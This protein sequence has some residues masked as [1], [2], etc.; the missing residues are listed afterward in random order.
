MKVDRRSFIRNSSMAA[1]AFTAGCATKGPTIINVGP[2]K[3]Y[4]WANLLQLG[5]NL[6]ND[7]VTDPAKPYDNRAAEFLRF[8]ENVWRDLTGKMRDIGMNML[9]IDL[10]EGLEYP[11]H[12]ELAVKGSW[13]PAK[14]RAELKRLRE[15]GIEPIPKLNFSATHDVWLKEYSMMLSTRI[16]HEVIGDL[17]KDVCEIFDNP[18]FVHIGMDEESEKLQTKFR[19]GVTRREDIWFND[20]KK[21]VATVER[22][23]ARAWM[24]GDPAWNYPEFYKHVPRSVMMS[25]WYYWKDAKEMEAKLDDPSFKIGDKRPDCPGQNHAAEFKAFMDL[26]KGGYEQMPCGTNWNNDGNMEAIV[27]YSIRRL[28]PAKMK[29]FL[30]TP[31]KCTWNEEKALK[32]HE[33]FFRLVDGIIKKYDA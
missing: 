25:N 18:R 7:H 33:S 29:G 27:D 6:W 14:L 9:V 5:C 30:L 13:S 17:V 11:S 31:W 26:Q 22:N 8:D 2:K 23:G 10:A 12:P 28:D 4:I 3:K 16:Y 1:A 15:M 32:K 20:L 21:I 24:W 19:Y